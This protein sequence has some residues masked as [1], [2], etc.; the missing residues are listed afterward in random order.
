MTTTATKST[1][2]TR[3]TLATPIRTWM[4]PIEP[5]MVLATPNRA[6]NR[7]CCTAIAMSWAA[8][9]FAAQ[10]LLSPPPPMPLP[11]PPPMPQRQSET[12]PHVMASVGWDCR[13][14][15]HRCDAQ[16]LPNDA[17]MCAAA[18]GHFPGCCSL[19][20]Y[21]WRCRRCSFRIPVIW[22]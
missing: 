6:T 13:C 3:M 9:R 2:T 18:G 16:R 15:C 11:P 21:R 10:P 22:S 7:N 20:C 19:C 5:S 12:V 17:T 8:R 4:V 14:G 1:T